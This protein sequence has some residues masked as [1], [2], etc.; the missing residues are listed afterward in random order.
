MCIKLYYR[1]FLNRPKNAEEQNFASVFS[2]LILK[3]PS[4]HEEASKAA[5]VMALPIT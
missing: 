4:F 5:S 3:N 2:N 1:K